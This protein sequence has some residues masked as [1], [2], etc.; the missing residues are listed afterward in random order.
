VSTTSRNTL[1]DGVRIA[2]R[3]RIE[4]MLGRGGSAT[5]Y[6]AVDEHD[7][8]SVA[9]KHLLADAGSIQHALF[10]RE[11]HTLMQIR[12]PAVIRV[13]DYGVTD[14]GPFYTM[15]LLD[16][17][18]LS[19][20]APLPWVEACRVLR[21]VASA[22]AILHS[23]R[24]IHRDISHRNVRVASDGR[25]K[26][27]D[28]GAM[29]P[30]GFVP[31][32]I[33]TPPFVSPE[34]ASRELLD[35]RTDLY[36]LGAL[37]YWLLTGKHLY[38]APTIR[39]LRAMWAAGALPAPEFPSQVPAALQQLTLA[40]MHRD[41]RARP[42]SAA[43][44]I[45]RLIAIA[46]LSSA[47]DA[48]IARSYLTNP[49]LI[50]R[51]GALDTLRVE[52]ER[53]RAGGRGGV[54]LIRGASGAG[55][56]RLLQEAVMQAQFAGFSVLQTSAHAAGQEPYAA[57][58]RLV[59]ALLQESPEAARLTT[60][61][62][63]VLSWAIPA[64]RQGSGMIV[65]PTQLEELRA[66]VHAELIALLLDLA[67]GERVLLAIDDLHACDEQSLAV[68]LSA[69]REGAR[70]PVILAALLDLGASAPATIRR[71]CERAVQL[72][73]L[74]PFSVAET[75][76]LVASLF[77]SSPHS[78]RVAGWMHEHARGNPLECMELARHLV[79]R[80]F[81]YYMDG[82]WMLPSAL[83][84][85]V[86][87]CLADAFH[88]RVAA[89]EPAQRSIAELLALHGRPAPLALCI[90]LSAVPDVATDDAGLFRALDQLVSAELLLVNGDRYAL[91]RDGLREALLAGLSQAQRSVLHQRI[92]DALIA[93]GLPDAAAKL[94]A[95]HHA[96]R[97]RAHMAG[98]AL[99]EEA[100]QEQRS[101]A[102][103]G[104]GLVPALQLALGLCESNAQAPVRCMR[105]RARLVNCAVAYD[106]KLITYAVPLLE[107]LRRDSGLAFW[108]ELD[109]SG[110]ERLGRAIARAQLEH[111]GT[112]PEQRGF[113]PIEALTELA[114]VAAGMLGVAIFDFD[115]ATIDHLAE[116]VAPFS[117]LD[118]QVPL[119]LVYDLVI[120][121][122]HIM[123]GRLQL[124]YAMRREVLQR[125]R[126]PAQYAGLP[127]P[128]R[129]ATLA[130]QLH[131]FG[132]WQ[133][134]RN[135]NEALAVADEI[136]A[137][138]M[139]AY[140]GAALQIR[141]LVHL[142]A[143]DAEAAKACQLGIDSLSLQSGPGR[144]TEIWLLAYLV[145]PHAAW[146]DVIALKRT[147]ERFAALVP[148][149]PAYR[150]HLYAALGA[151][152]R[153]RGQVAESKRA[154]E[155]SLALSGTFGARMVAT[156]QYIETLV[157][158]GEFRR[159]L[160]LANQHFEAIE[161]GESE[162]AF[163]QDLLP[164]TAL[165]EARLG[166]VGAAA[167][168]LEAAIAA[169]DTA[170]RSLAWRVRLHEA[171]ARVAIEAR[172]SKAF[173]LHAARMAEL[174]RA[175]SSTTLLRHLMLVEDG[176]RLG[177]GPRGAPVRVR[178]SGEANMPTVQERRSPTAQELERRADMRDRCE[179]ALSL[180]LED[181]RA[182]G[183]VLFADGP[184]GFQMLAKSAQEAVPSE[185]L[186]AAQAFA[187][188]AA[189]VERAK[190][191][192]D[193]WISG[194]GDR[195]E[196][197]ELQVPGSQGPA[198]VGVAALRLAQQADH[199]MPSAAWLSA[200]ARALQE[201]V[202]LSTGQ[203]FGAWMELG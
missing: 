25:T 40:L 160:E 127:E 151:Y 75:E 159:A 74:R 148:E 124:G 68:L 184:N 147:A 181:V 185:L 137:L 82:A 97:G 60:E 28:F 102:E 59:E 27:I 77:G 103:L 117:D 44:V 113:A 87:S 17:D 172:D 201:A 33:G 12:H 158:A 115:G 150:S 188:S 145:G 192:A 39:E 179:H 108:P 35:Q 156:S 197:L 153:E 38:P 5:V 191:H 67:A 18:D 76:L 112:A 70:G 152:Y 22:L 92:A 198:L 36:S 105:L 186:A 3:Y 53:A 2:G 121:I 98:V 96:M 167:H 118:K 81:A 196:L 31:D 177:V 30:M 26:L 43:E 84:A 165:A 163:R 9:L 23:R 138:E 72:I 178:S 37:A 173:E 130:T 93:R 42:S 62:R 120:L 176:A 48:S 78:P 94:E 114:M 162:R 91:S 149:S 95:G 180:L 79:E 175:C 46:G 200:I 52:L 161:D 183:G 141:L 129:K 169:P 49:Q 135:S 189:Q 139:K 15:E 61:R 199:R 155:H 194:S 126:D 195:Y 110:R 111:D 8:S 142:Y 51:Q 73:D 119:T 86:P 104:E 107:Q 136:D 57:I 90:A 11:Y 19:E 125:L 166:A 13:F 146:G 21:D 157:A 66:R 32:L 122:Q 7:D 134:P 193:V 83:P 24:V 174:L 203:P 154:L 20:L 144:Q 182:L 47:D 50:G 65:R 54:Q 143:G 101:L 69:S 89:L 164:L 55:K 14:D 109:G 140:Q 4:R 29:A 170:A 190:A 128:A 34:A 80:R 132:M 45:D 16:G 10:Q 123:H 168:A 133:A 202:E 116:V 58:A 64:L 131:A 88:A 85:G 171:R 99:V 106:K 71:F 63:A 100:I 6:S 1:A 187:D 41:A 56:S